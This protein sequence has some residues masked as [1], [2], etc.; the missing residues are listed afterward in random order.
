MF[1]ELVSCPFNKNHMFKKARLVYH[2]N[3]CKDKVKVI[4]LFAQCRYNRLHYLRKHEIQKHE[5]EC[6]DREMLHNI[7][8]SL[9]KQHHKVDRE[10]ER[11]RDRKAFIRQER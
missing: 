6:E 3:S 8:D 7:L 2:L 11:S 1:E 10:R 9:Q 4:H 5:E